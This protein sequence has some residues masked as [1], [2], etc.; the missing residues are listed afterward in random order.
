MKSCMLKLFLILIIFCISDKMYAQKSQVMIISGKVVDYKSRPVEGAEIAVYQQLFNYDVGKEYGKLIE[1]FEKTDSNGNFAVN[2]DILTV[3]GIACIVARKEGFALGW[4]IFYT[5]LGRPDNKLIV[6]EKPTSLSGIL[7]DEKGHPVANAKV[8]AVPKSSYSRNL[9]QSPIIEPKQWFITKT[10]ANGRFRFDNFSAD[11]NTDFRVEAPGWSLTYRYTTNFMSAFGFAAGSSD[12]QLVL[13][14]ERTITGKVIDAESRAAIKGVKLYFQPA[15][16]EKNNNPYYPKE[17]IT[18][19]NGIFSFK[20]LPPGEHY[21]DVFFD[22]T[23]Q[24][25]NKRVKFEIN[26]DDTVKEVSI[27][28][29]KG[30]LAEITIRE[31]ETKEPIS[32]VNVYFYK[33]L[34]DGKSS[35]RKDVISGNDGIIR[36]WAP[37]G[38]CGFRVDCTGYSPSRMDNELIMITQGQTAK[39]EILLDTVQK[40][41]GIV[42]DEN[43]KPVSGVLAAANPVGGTDSTDKEGRFEIELDPEQPCKRLIACDKA[44]NLAAITEVGDISKPI[45]ITLKPALSITGQVTDPDG[46]GIPAARLALALRASSYTVSLGDE[47]LTDSQGRFELDAIPA[48]EEGMEYRISV[49][50]SG[51]GSREYDRISINNE[52]GTKLELNAIVLR[53]ADQSL[54]GIVEDA[55]GTPAVGVPVMMFGKGQPIRNTVTDKSG[56]FILKRVCKGPFRIQAGMGNSQIEP[57][58]LKGDEID[59]NVKVILGQDLTY[60]P[61]Q[62]LINKP[63]PDI[64]DFGMKQ[65]DMKGKILLVC[66]FDLEQRP[67]RNCITQLNKKAKELESKD[68]EIIAVQAS[69]IEQTKL[70]EWIK[71]NNIELPVR[72]IKANEEQTRLDW[73]VKALPWLILTNKELMV[74]DEGFSIS[75]IEEKIK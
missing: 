20:G 33:A 46:R 32:G 8:Q 71:E 10:D 21:A 65:E 36:L 67:S 42:I 41:S 16:I 37:P 26:P 57:G 7:V 23:S 43:G 5:P 66:F 39:R 9:E 2:S 45:Q 69:K 51:Y 4:D 47:V 12:I 14:P 63:M 49:Y 62:N 28:A 27:E 50:S 1:H 48:I 70:D 61:Y 72:M 35:F 11:V 56:K 68:I 64:S 75:E 74:T 13:P 38:E 31:A 34:Q 6:L 52:S 58:F 15:D 17:V 59:E 24:L 18:D 29:N 40:I 25:V 30:S 19:S 60:R 73:G 22:E 44:N 55:N 53:P 3:R 54:S